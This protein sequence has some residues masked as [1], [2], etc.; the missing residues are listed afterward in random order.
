MA[1]VD[2]RR[3]HALELEDARTKVRE[4]EPR[5]REKYGITISW[6]GDR[7]QVKG[8]GVSGTVELSGNS[9]SLSLKLGLLLRPMA[10]K[11]QT[12]VERALDGALG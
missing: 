12:A 1:H 6:T 8:R 4:I 9:V 5:L 3:E 10:G 7:G 11:I 2:V